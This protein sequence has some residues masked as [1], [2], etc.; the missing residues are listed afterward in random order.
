MRLNKQHRYY[1]EDLGNILKIKGIDILK[2]KSVLITGATGMVGECLIDALMKFNNQ[3]SACVSIIAVGRDK[4]K[5]SMRLGEYYS[6]PFFHFIQQDVRDPLPEEIIVDY[7]IPLASNTH[8]LAYSKYPV[9]TV[10]INVKGAENALKK[11]RQCGAVVLYPSSVEVYGNGADTFDESYTGKLNLSNSRACYTESKRV[12]EALCQ[13]YVAEYGVDCKI[14]RLS[15]LFGPT[16]LESDTKA[17]SQFILKALAR[18]DIVLK[19]KGEQ[20]FSYTYIADAVQAILFVLV[21]GECGQAYNIASDKCNVKLADFAK[22]C[23]NLA[24]TSVVFDLP[25]EVEAKG[26]SVAMKA[27]LSTD[28]LQALGWTASYSFREAIDKTIKILDGRYS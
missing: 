25:S 16:M 10:E 22:E 13:S 2:G 5:A 23:A 18:E 9:E 11:A 28:K 26:Y 6:S 27:I 24:G 20:F 1:Q 21:N 19:S 4:D 7:I 14:V 8:P 3:Q 12:C 17:S 15:R